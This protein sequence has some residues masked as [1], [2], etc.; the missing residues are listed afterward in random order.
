MKIEFHWFIKNSLKSNLGKFCFTVL[1]DHFRCEHTFRSSD[2]VILPG[3]IKDKK[4]TLI[5][6]LTTDVFMSNISFMFYDQLANF[7]QHIKLIYWAIHSQK[8][9]SLMYLSFGCFVAKFSTKN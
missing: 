3:L 8:I 1:G 5:K 4:Q 6:I 2:A 7:P 9:N